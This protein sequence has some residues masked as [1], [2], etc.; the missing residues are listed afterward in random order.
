MTARKKKLNILSILII[1]AIVGVIATLLIPTY[2]IYKNRANYSK[3][4]HIA[5]A[6]QTTV[7]NC[8]KKTHHLDRCALG[9]HGIPRHVH[10]RDRRYIKSIDIAKGVIVIIPKAHRGIMEEDTLVYIPNIQHGKI[11]WTAAGRSVEKGFAN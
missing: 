4:V 6:Y 5:S 3:I 9:R 2:R 11:V 10:R 1:V 8:F 7:S